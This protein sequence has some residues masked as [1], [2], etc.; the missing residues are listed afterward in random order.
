MDN[1]TYSEA[2]KEGFYSYLDNGS[3]SRNP[4]SFNHQYQECI[5]FSVGEDDALAFLSIGDSYGLKIKQASFTDLVSKH[6]WSKKP[7]DC[8]GISIPDSMVIIGKSDN[9]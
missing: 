6:T 8:H 7:L 1:V 2:R 4:Y 3:D 9:Q 5:D